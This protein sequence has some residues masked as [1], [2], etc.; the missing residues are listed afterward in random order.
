MIKPNGI[1]HIAIM[2]ADIKKHI[3]F[4]SDVLGCRLVAIFDMHGVPGGLHAFL[5]LD[6]HTSFSVVQIEGTADI[7]I[8][9][10]I[11]HAGTGAG[12]SAPG[13]MQHL[14][15][16]VDSPTDLLNMR[17]RIRTKGVTVIGPL[18]HGMCQSIYFAGPDQLTLEVACSDAAIDPKR[19]IDP[20]TLAK[21]GISA[22]EAALYA[23]PDDY[24]GEGG[25]VAQPPYDPAQPHMA[26]PDAA[27]RQMITAPDA[28]IAAMASYAEPPVKA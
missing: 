7:P 11:T 28:L 5:H 15:F 18:D 20:G 12:K 21:A 14:A 16:K 25:A 4:F 24:A 8:E 10:G 13:T 26:Y 2:A 1:H 23:A 19:W 22:D 6:D 3:A 9:L 27:Y 17:D